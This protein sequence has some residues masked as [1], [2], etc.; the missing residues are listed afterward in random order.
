MM[1]RPWRVLFHSLGLLVSAV[2]LVYLGFRSLVLSV[3]G[4]KWSEMAVGLWSWLVS[5]VLGSLELSSLGVVYCVLGV[6]VLC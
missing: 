5:G 1:L 2:L 4:A 6:V 3:S